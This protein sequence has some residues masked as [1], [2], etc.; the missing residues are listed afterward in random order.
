[1]RRHG[2]TLV[3]LLVVIAIIGALVAL[4]LPAVQSSREAARRTSCIN[5]LRQLG[6]AMQNHVSAK[7]HFPPGAVAR[8]YPIEPSAAWTFYRWSALAELT[9]YLENTAAHDALDLTVALYGLDLEVTAENRDAVAIFVPEFLC[10]SDEQRAVDN[11]FGPTNYAVCTGAG[12][13]GGSPRESFGVFYV[14]SKIRPAQITDGTSHTGVA[15]ESL[16]GQPRD[17]AHDVRYEYKFAFRAPLTEGLCNTSQQWN[18]TDPRGFAWV[19][20]EYRSA[21][22]NHYL[23]PNSDTAD[24]VGVL[25]AGDPKIRFTPYGWRTAR[26]HHPGGVNLLLA[27]GS[28]QKTSDDVELATWQ[29][30][31]TRAGGEISRQ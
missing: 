8:E 22:Y 10:P 23:T 25:L 16:L 30:M 18:F 5:N 4:L 17:D 15:S 28:V 2:F 7:R 21:L 6:L 12:E 1:M 3:E 26:S 24:C 9:P 29:A 11:Q 31:S 19:N 20:G 14:N 13:Y 27:D